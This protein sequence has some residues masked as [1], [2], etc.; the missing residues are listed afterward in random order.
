VNTT[1]V[2]DPSLNS[3]YVG[4]SLTSQRIS[5][6]AAVYNGAIYITGFKLLKGTKYLEYHSVCP[7]EKI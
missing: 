7:R 4:I 6:C 5:P 2:Y 3:W 1:Y